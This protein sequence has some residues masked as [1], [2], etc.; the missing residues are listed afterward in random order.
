MMSI[1][2]TATPSEGSFV[3]FSHGGKIRPGVVLRICDD[4]RLFVLSGT[5][6]E[7]PVGLK[8]VLV[9]P[10]T[11]D[12]IVGELKLPTWFHEHGAGVVPLAKIESVYGFASSDLLV[13]LGAVVGHRASRA[14]K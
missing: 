1:S 12:A 13:R 4:G 8:F 9:N 2:R 7:P 11:R 10:G 3:W 5:S 6:K 14:P